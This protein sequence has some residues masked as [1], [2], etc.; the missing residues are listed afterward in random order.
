MLD[1]LKSIRDILLADGTIT[2]YVSSRVYLA[3]KPVINTASGSYPQ[4]TMNVDD[5]STDSV[6]NTCGPILYI[7]IWSKTIPGSTGGA[8]EAKL[9][10]KRIYQL[11]DAR[12]DLLGEPLK[13]Y[14]IWKDSSTLLF[15]DDTQVWHQ[16]IRFRVEMDGYSA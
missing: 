8:T 2:G 14:Q 13:I 10:A 11:I 7:D 3:F 12:Q 6:T 4:I 16:S 9:I 1:L 15:E 5:G